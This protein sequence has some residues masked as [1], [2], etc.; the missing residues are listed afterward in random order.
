[1]ERDKT[2]NPVGRRTPEDGGPEERRGV[3]PSDRGEKRRPGHTWR[4]LVV[5]VIAAIVL[6]AGA[7]LILGGTYGF[8][9][10]GAAA[11][12]GAGA[13]RDCCAPPE[14]GQGGK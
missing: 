11:G 7:T 1:M 5:A 3:A 10:Q 9:R 4:G 2:W 12:C 8:T 13:V 6:S 14:S